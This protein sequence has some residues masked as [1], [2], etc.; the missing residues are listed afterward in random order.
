MVS[1]PLNSVSQHGNL[2]QVGVKIKN[3][4]NHHL[5]AFSL[6]CKKNKG[7]KPFFIAAWSKSLKTSSTSSSGTAMAPRLHI[8]VQKTTVEITH[9]PSPKSIQSGQIISNHD[10]SPRFPW[11]KGMSLPKSYIPFGCEVTVIWPESM[12]FCLKWT[13]FTERPLT[14]AAFP[15]S[16]L[17]SRYIPKPL[18]ISKVSKLSMQ[19]RCWVAD[20]VWA[21]CPSRVSQEKKLAVNLEWFGSYFTMP[22]ILL[23]REPSLI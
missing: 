7:P 13:N 12:D 3:L 14:R 4:W 16:I 5:V 8:S 19:I 23:E 15:I 11:T 1:T 18:E 22:T 10:I 9:W 17:T 2:P 20:L 21:F 6:R